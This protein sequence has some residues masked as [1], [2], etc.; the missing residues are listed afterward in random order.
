[1]SFLIYFSSSKFFLQVSSIKRIL[2]GIQR[3]KTNRQ[4]LERKLVTRLLY[5]I[6]FADELLQKDKK[7]KEEP[8]SMFQRQR[9][10][11]L[12]AELAKKF[13]VKYAPLP[14]MERPG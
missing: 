5:F 10:D 1:M 13:P 11:V 2:V 6:N 9:V 14:H 7:K 12:L 8:S 4:E 3:S